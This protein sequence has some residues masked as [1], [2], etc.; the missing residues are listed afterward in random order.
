MIFNECTSRYTYHILVLFSFS[1]FQRYFSFYI[2]LTIGLDKA[3]NKKVPH[4][5]FHVLFF[6]CKC[7]H[8]DVV[9]WFVEVWQEE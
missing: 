3:S 2:V 7:S 4:R 5:D 9:V 8:C 6:S 1:S